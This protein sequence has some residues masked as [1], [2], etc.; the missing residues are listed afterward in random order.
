MVE[1][2][3]TA[4]QRLKEIAQG[5]GIELPAELDD[6]HRQK[7]DQ[8]SALSGPEFDAQSTQGQVEKH[9]QAVDLFTR[10]AEEGQDADLQTFA[11][12]TTPLL[13]GHLKEDTEL[14]QP[15]EA[16]GQ[17]ARTDTGTGT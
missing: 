11:Q 15:M 8:L 6:Q 4:S 3:T 5:K 12:E 14:P 9:Q 10:H 7:I 2:H 1:D 16:R 17:I 13:A